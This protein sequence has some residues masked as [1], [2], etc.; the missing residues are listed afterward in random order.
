MRILVNNDEIKTKISIRWFGDYQQAARSLSFSYLPVEKSCRVGDKVVMY[1]NDGQLVFT[2]MCI[3]AHYNTSQKYY[4]VTCMDLLYNFLQSKS[5]GRYTG[6]SSDI[7]RKVCNI[8]NLNSKINLS[9][10]SQQLITTGDF[11][12]Y[13]VM[14]KSVRRDI[15]NEF[16][17]IRALGNDVYLDIPSESETVA[18]LTS[19]TNIITADYSENIQNMINK[20]TVIDDFGAVLNTR[21]N[22]ADLQK[23]G[24]MQDVVTEQYTDDFKLVMPELHGIDYTASLSIKGDIKC[25]AG[26]NV[27]IIEPHTGFNGKFFILND[28][29]VWQDNQYITNLGILYHG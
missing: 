29:H 6:T 27:N 25:I 21:Q 24:L 14:A 17:N 5:F 7:C 4:D 15:G 18:T 9:G 28:E 1:D 8:F 10:Q 16:F 23:F 20:I 2:G 26:M 3:D 22:S 11:T 13:D 12:Y 19:Q